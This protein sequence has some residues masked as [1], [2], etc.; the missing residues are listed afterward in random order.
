MSQ[1]DILSDYS[2]KELLEIPESILRL[3]NLRMLYLEGNFLKTLPDNF[4][5]LLPNLTWLDIR[6][7]Q[8]VDIPSTICDHKNLQT[9]LLQNNQL[10]FLPNEIGKKLIFYQ[11]L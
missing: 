9:L 5:A 10:E 7:N 3:S 2:K 4:F 6:N 11:L 1:L 8:L